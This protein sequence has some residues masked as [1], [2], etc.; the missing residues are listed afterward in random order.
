MTTTS[1]RPETDTAETDATSVYRYYDAHGVLLY[2]GI[3][4]RGMTRQHEHNQAQPWWTHVVRQEVDHHP[5]R[6]LAGAAEKRLIRE[7][8]PPY[9]VQ[10]NPDHRALRAQY[11]AFVA[12]V[13]DTVWAPPMPMV[14]PVYRTPFL[15]RDN[16]RAF[17]SLPGFAELAASID[18]NH[19]GGHFPIKDDDKRHAGLT[20]LS[21]ND[22][23]VTAYIGCHAVSE[24]TQ[25]ARLRLSCLSQKPLRTTVKAFRSTATPAGRWT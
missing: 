4:S 15:D 13:G 6:L 8:R 22:L 16:L 12:G 18:I 9:N 3:T 25:R 1:Y 19:H 20:A 21:R 24:D 5:T 11:E 2:V 14:L 17:T 23:T 7:H 10:H